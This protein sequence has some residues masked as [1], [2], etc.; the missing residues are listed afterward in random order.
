[1]PWQT[2][3]V[4]E[5][6]RRMRAEKPVLLNC[7]GIASPLLL[8]GGAPQLAIAKKN[9]ERVKITVNNYYS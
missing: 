9:V 3:K 5:V 8:I 1:M 4:N 7:R 2:R 6:R